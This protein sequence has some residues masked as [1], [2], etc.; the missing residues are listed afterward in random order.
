MARLLEQR[1]RFTKNAIYEAAIEILS[2]DGFD[3]LTMERIAETAGVAKGSVYNYFSNKEAL[4]RFVFEGAFGPLLNSIQ[5]I[6]AGDDGAQGKF[7]SVFR[8]WFEY[9][10]ECRGVLNLLLNEHAIH[11]VVERKDREKP[12]EHFAKIIDQGVG[13]G[14]FRPVDSMRFAKL[15]L[16]AARALSDEQLCVE[17]PWPV[18]DLVELMLDFFVNGVGKY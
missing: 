13:E 17:G 6:A 5:T 15:L 3:A 2:G 12:A 16:G 18:D 4:I 8:V 7:R 1:K 9:M 10:A 14:V 11:R